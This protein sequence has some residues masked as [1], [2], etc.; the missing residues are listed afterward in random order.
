MLNHFVTVRIMRTRSMIRP[1]DVTELNFLQGLVRMN[2][3]RKIGF[4]Q[5]ILFA[6][7]NRCMEF[8]PAAAGTQADILNHG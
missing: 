1:F 4:Q 5:L 2:A 8:H 7:L 3:D 6:P